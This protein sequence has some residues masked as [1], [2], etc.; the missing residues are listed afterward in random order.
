MVAKMIKK[1]VFYM[2]SGTLEK[3]NDSRSRSL[4]TG[5]E[6]VAVAAARVVELLPRSSLKGIHKSRCLQNDCENHFSVGF[7][8]SKGGHTRA[9]L[10]K[11]ENPNSKLC[12]G[13]EKT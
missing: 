13:N 1:H 12:L 3:N 7:K 11:R 6:N 9:S 5:L 4:D 2:K 8:V 10:N